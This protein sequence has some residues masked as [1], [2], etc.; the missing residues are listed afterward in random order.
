MRDLETGKE[1]ADQIINTSGGTVWAADSK[2]FFYIVQ[3]E[4]HRPHKVF[5]HTLGDDAANDRLVYEE[6]NPGFFLSL[7]K[8]SSGNFILIDANDHITSEIRYIPADKADSDPILVAERV[9]GREY[10]VEDDGETLYIVTNADDAIDFKM[11]TL[12]SLRLVL[13]TGLT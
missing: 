13:K 1:L 10:G 8:T 9:T 3:D 7:N 6:K 5:Q 4:N 11:V 2:S 12:P